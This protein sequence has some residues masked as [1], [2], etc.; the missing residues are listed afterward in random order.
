MTGGGD[1]IS[2]LAGVY[3]WDQTNSNRGLEWSHADWTHAAPAGPRQILDFADVLASP[4]CN[5]TAQQR[6]RNFN[7]VVRADGIV[8][9]SDGDNGLGAVQ[10]SW[11]LPCSRAHPLVPFGLY[12]P[13][14]NFSIFNSTDGFNG[15]DRSSLAEQVAW[16]TSARSRSKSRTNGTSPSAIDSMS[17]TMRTGAR[18]RRRQSVGP[19]GAAPDHDRHALR[20]RGPRVERADHP[21]R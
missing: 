8:G 1:R 17:R 7:G 15:S 9:P 3:T 20:Q 5:T 11:P 21:G 12:I 19:H 13:A 4:T 10:D 6:G 18:S 2:W 14:I 16:R